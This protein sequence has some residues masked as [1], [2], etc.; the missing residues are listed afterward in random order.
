MKRG[1]DRATILSIGL[2]VSLGVLGGC[3]AI[4][5]HRNYEVI[6]DGF[7]HEYNLMESFHSVYNPQESPVMVILK[8]LP[9]D[10]VTYTMGPLLPLIPVMQRGAPA[11]TL[12]AD[13]TLMAL[14]LAADDTLDINWAGLRVTTD[15]GVPVPLRFQDLPERWDDIM[16]M[17]HHRRHAK[18]VEF[19]CVFP[20]DAGPHPNL[21]LLLPEFTVGSAP[22]T[23]P[24][25]EIEVKEGTRL[26]WGFP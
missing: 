4:V 13:F 6:N 7:Q 23:F 22:T 3:S 9:Y 11:D 8:V 15:D 21:V 16:S 14:E 2:G 18:Q 25:L 26:M 17:K 20:A 24:P 19:R 12:P 1:L 10:Q 5:K